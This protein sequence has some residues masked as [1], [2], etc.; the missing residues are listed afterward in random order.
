[1]APEL[2]SSPHQR[3]F[4]RLLLSPNPTINALAYTRFWSISSNF[5]FFPASP[6]KQLLY[7]FA[8]FGLHRVSLVF[9]LAAR[10]V[11][12]IDPFSRWGVR[13]PAAESAAEKDHHKQ[14][15]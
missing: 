7:P 12:G 11:K 9:L 3:R 6:G 10:S 1:L 4:F 5:P 14:Y 15:K 2:T 8:G 13:F